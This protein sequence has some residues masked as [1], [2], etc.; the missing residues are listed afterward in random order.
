MLELSL[1]TTFSAFTL[2]II[3]LSVHSQ[4]SVQVIDSITQEPIPFATVL[5]GPHQGTITNDEGVFL[6]ETS[7]FRDS[8][9]IT[10][11]GYTGRTWTQSP[12]DTILYLSPKTFELDQVILGVE[13][14]EA[15]EIIDR[16]RDG[17]ETQY[18]FT[19][20]K[21]KTFYRATYQ[22]QI[23]RLETKFKKSTIEE[24]TEKRIDSVLGTLPRQS[25]YF[26]E[27]LADVW[28]SDPKNHKM[29]I[30]KALKVQDKTQE[31]SFASIEKMFQQLINR[32]V[33]PDS[34]FK[35]KSGIIGTKIPVDSIME[36]QQQRENYQKK[37][38]A[39]EFFNYRKKAIVNLLHHPVYH[40]KTEIDVVEHPGRYVF[41]KNGINEVDGELV[42]VLDYKPEKGKGFK[43]TLY[44]HTED[45]AIVRIDF[46]STGGVYDKHFNMFGVRYNT[47][48]YSGTHLFGKTNGK[49]TLRYMTESQTE[50]TQIDRP[51][52]IIEKNKHVRG[53]RKQN[54]VSFDIDF[55]L[56]DGMRKELVIVDTQSHSEGDYEAI[57]ENTQVQM[58]YLPAYDP[59]FWTGYTVLPP[60]TM[61]QELRL[62][63][64]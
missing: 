22:Q 28:T 27:T 31:A 12:T 6:F 8:L 11:I 56:R 64:E 52:K 61:I 54:E 19:N 41:T 57:S 32:N 46:K 49:Y 60:T 2:T 42:Y 36:A 4:Q 37:L 47:L 29:N 3:S 53:R 18:Q 16:C 13:D 55:V 38:E 20:L 51:L 23:K 25:V 17:L 45:F 1:Q 50:E 34:Y 26:S 24:I 62:E 44:V 43:G 5:F 58:N 14:L 39:T 10:S 35:I 21:Q 63:R 7:K 40:S 15:E 9:R 59:N 30:V 48:R 33:K